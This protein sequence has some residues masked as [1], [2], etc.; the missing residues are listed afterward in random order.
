MKEGDDFIVSSSG[1]EPASSAF[2]SIEDLA[3][4]L[5][6]P[7]SKYCNVYDV[8]FKDLDDALVDNNLCLQEEVEVM[9]AEPQYGI[10]GEVGRSASYYNPFRIADILDPPEFCGDYLEFGV[11]GY[12]FCANAHVS[13]LLKVL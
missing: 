2:A 3:L 12:K 8:L 4:K 13:R 11:H 5:I 9:L 6:S 7:I 1:R 10:F